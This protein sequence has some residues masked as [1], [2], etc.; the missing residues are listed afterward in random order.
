LKGVNGKTDL[1]TFPKL[2]KLKGFL[3]QLQFGIRTLK[4]QKFLFA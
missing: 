1:S 2:A 4:R 3:R